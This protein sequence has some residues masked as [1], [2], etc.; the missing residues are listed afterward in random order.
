MINLS[1]QSSA[2]HLISA[3]WYA[4]CLAIVNWFF[5]P[6]LQAPSSTTRSTTEAPLDISYIGSM[7][8][9][10]SGNSQISGLYMVFFVAATVAAF[11][12]PLGILLRRKVRGPGEA[13]DETG[14]LQKYEDLRNMRDQHETAAI[15]SDL[16]EKDGAGAWPPKADHDSWPAPLKP[17]KDIYLECVPSL[18]MADASTDDDVNQKRRGR[19]RSLMRNLLDERVNLAEF[20]EIM[21]AVEAGDISACRRDAYNG[22]YCCIAVYR[23]AYRSVLPAQSRR[24]CE[25]PLTSLDGRQSLL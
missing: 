25:T 17:Y 9:L 11:C 23:H 7:F 24:L 8:G 19:Y 4:V 6:I 5:T 16:V 20:E 1:F 3:M 18:P 14:N 15:L 13:V 22:F 21:K 2:R 10:S 12:A